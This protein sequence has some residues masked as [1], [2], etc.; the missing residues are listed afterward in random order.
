MAEDTL[1]RETGYP[2]FAISIKL[3]LANAE[4]VNP[5][6]LGSWEKHSRAC[7]NGLCCLLNS[8]D[9]VTFG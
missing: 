1:P 8:Y 7:K 2:L 6:M 4:T 5:L 3:P 9:A